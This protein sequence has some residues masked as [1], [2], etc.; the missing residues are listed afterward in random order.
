MFIKA[1]KPYVFSTF[2]SQDSLLTAEW[3]ELKRTLQVRMTSIY[4]LL[5]IYPGCD[6]LNLQ[7]LE[8]LK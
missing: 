7:A 1:K 2:F 5:V 4:L 6:P 3:E 8:M